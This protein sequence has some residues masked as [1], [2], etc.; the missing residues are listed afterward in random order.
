MGR[1]NLKLSGLGQ[2]RA[3]RN[4]GKRQLNV[5]GH[6]QRMKNRLVQWYEMDWNIQRSGGRGRPN[7]TAKEAVLR[8][9]GVVRIQTP[10]PPPQLCKP[11]RKLDPTYIFT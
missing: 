2:S 1:N 7:T 3:G 11:R 6:R 8:A 10:P 9:E 5:A 4:A